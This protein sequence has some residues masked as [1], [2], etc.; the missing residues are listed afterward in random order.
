[1]DLTEEING[2]KLSFPSF[3]LCFKSFFTPAESV[4]YILGLP[5]IACFR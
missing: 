5:L 1:M 2:V 3:G 4:P